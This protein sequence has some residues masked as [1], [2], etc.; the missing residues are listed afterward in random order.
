MISKEKKAEIIA[1]YGRKA[2]DT[3]SPEVHPDGTGG[4]RTGQRFAV[5]PERRR[6]RNSPEAG[7]GRFGRLH[8][9]HAATVVLYD[10]DSRIDLVLQQ[11]QE[12]EG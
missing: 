7:G 4:C 9:G 3:G 6:G 1:Q 8:R 12:T 5:E 10:A 11:G 2:G